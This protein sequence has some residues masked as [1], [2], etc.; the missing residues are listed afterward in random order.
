MPDGPPLSVPTETRTVTAVRFLASKSASTHMGGSRLSSVA[1]FPFCSPHSFTS[2]L[3]G[4]PPPS[5]FRKNSRLTF[6]KLRSNDDTIRLFA[7]RIAAFSVLL[8]DDGCGHKQTV[9]SRTQRL[10]IICRMPLLDTSRLRE[11]HALEVTTGAGV[12]PLKPDCRKQ[13]NEL[14]TSAL[15]SLRV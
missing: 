1:G 3:I 4:A 10:R 12:V 2:H 7:R 15:P 9:S 14:S 5:F 11:A 8:V 13:A 6:G